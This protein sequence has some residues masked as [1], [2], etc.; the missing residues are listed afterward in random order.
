MRV[1]EADLM[2]RWLAVHES[3]YDS[4]D[5]NVYVGAGRDPGPAY[6]EWVRRSAIFSSRLRMD[7][8]A[9]RGAQAT[10]IELKNVAYP[11]GAQKLTVYGAVWASD[12]PMALKPLLLLVCR[13]M[14]PATWA[15]TAAAGISVNVLGFV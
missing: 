7:A 2:R 10:I 3:E 9:F 8:I 14:D 12:N 1:T 15:N 13:G 4:F 5:Y 11:S 6:E